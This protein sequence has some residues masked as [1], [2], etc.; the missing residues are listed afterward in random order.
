[1]STSPDKMKFVRDSEKWIA[2][3]IETNTKHFLKYI[4]NRK[5]ARRVVGPLN[6]RRMKGLRKK[7]RW[8]K[9]QMHSLI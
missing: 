5:P 8:Q 6:N 9:I 3:N 1:M 7:R 2:N 4:R